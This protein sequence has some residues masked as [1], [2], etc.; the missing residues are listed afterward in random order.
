MDTTSFFDH[1]CRQ[2]VL[3]CILI[4]DDKGIIIDANQAFLDNFGYNKKELIGQ[5]F[6]TLFNLSDRNQNKPETELA[7]IL[8]D[9]HALD[10]NYILNKD[11]KEIWVTGEAM[12]IK[13]KAGKSY[14][15]KDVVNLQSRNHVEYFYIETEELM[16]KIFEGNKE[17]AV[18]VLDGIGKIIKVNQGFLNLFQI[19]EMP[20]SGSS[21]S[22]LNHVF[23][24]TPAL[25][26]E[27]REILIRNIPL[28]KSFALNTVNGETI[29]LKFTVKVL[30]REER[31]I[32]I[33]IEKV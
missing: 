2:A 30:G 12:L 27:I 3:N 22:Q 9:G 17:T 13:T 26:N 4:M 18:V 7:T 28:K 10:E 14:I 6:R 25:R 31:K 29:P 16:E 8:K 20:A 5:H 33:I 1:Y 11:G 21:L 15:V 23:W 32:Y 24:N 19:A